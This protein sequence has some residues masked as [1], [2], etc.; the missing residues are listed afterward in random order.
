M[1]RRHMPLRPTYPA[2]FELPASFK[3]P[4]C[5][6]AEASTGPDRDPSRLPFS[7]P[8]ATMNLAVSPRKLWEHPNPHDTAMWRFMQESNRRH[9]LHLQTFW[10]LYNWSCDNRCH[11]YRQLWEFQAWIHEGSYTRVVDEAIPV[12]KLPR[13]F[14]GVRLN[15]AENF[16]WTPAPH[17]G[18]VRS[19]QVR[20]HDKIALTEVREGN[21]DLVHVTFGELRQRVARLASA[22]H[23]A[24]LVE[25]D[26]VVMVGAHACQTLV[27]FLATAWLGAIFSSSSTDMGVSGLLQRI[28][29]VRPK[30]IFFDDGAVYNGKEVDLRDKIRAIINRLASSADL[31]K[32]IAVP[33]FADRPYDVSAIARTQSLEQFVEKASD[34]PPPPI[35]RIA[36]QDPVVVYF[37]SG[38]TGVP[39]AIV[40]GVGPVLINLSRELIL[41]AD[42]KAD[43]VGLQYTTTGW[44]MYM[45]SVAAI[46]VGG[47]AVL[48]DGSP[49]VPDPTVLLRVAEQQRVTYLGIS[50]RWM[51]E[52]S[53]RNMSPRNVADLSSLRMVGSTG[54]VLPD[55]MF[56]WFYDEAFPGHTQLFNQSGGTDIVGSFA[57]GNPL[58]A[59][60]V[61][62]CV[63]PCLG[64]RLQVFD[65][66]ISEGKPVPAGTPGD[67]VA[68]TAFPNVP[69]F[70]W[71]DS[72]PAPGTKY[73]DSYFDRFRNVWTH[74]DFI[75]FHPVTGAVIFLGRSDGVLNPSGVR[76]GSADIYAVVERGFAAEVADSLCVGQRRRQDSDESVLL[77]VV[78]R[79]GKPLTTSLVSRI[80]KAI[81]RD[82]SKRH[83][84]KYIF[85]AP[86]LPVTVNGKKV[87]LPVKA[88]VS[89]KTVTP[90]GTLLNPHSLEFF[91][92][93]QRVEELVE[94]TKAKL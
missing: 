34:T 67:L 53:K 69:V 9:G 30:F 28:V 18:S 8:S 58:M 14:E 82:L 92:R 60:H 63:A 49:F 15:L 56:H 25:G 66:E 32:L 93:F 55:Q 3:Q 43:D 6:E 36:F 33:R 61:G 62:G 52:L 44:I 83:V 24:G 78:M 70:F 41:H 45:M 86:E 7:S 37:S 71:G 84:P 91:Y 65:S 23:A 13:W 16:L 10:D 94:G 75:V 89:G 57:L 47:R 87:E 88:I 50:P 74:G 42:M 48:Y 21:S 12:S 64:I 35:K 11:F 76:F 2:S 31:A 20:H 79:P 51:A 81:A 5:S 77:F 72:Q 59:I 80:N 4:L 46:P 39:K 90:S 68:T 29:L 17:D 40:H 1:K 26:R 73:Y 85:E 19:T 54:T 27:V 22:L 38:T